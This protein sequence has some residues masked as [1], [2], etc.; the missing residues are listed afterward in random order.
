MRSHVRNRFAGA[1]A[2]VCVSALAA[3]AQTPP[4]P[5]LYPPSDAAADVAAALAASK[6]DGK[7]VLLDFGADWCPDCRVLGTLMDAPAVAPFLQANFHVVH[8]DVGRRDKNLDVVAKYHATADAWIPAVVVLDAA[9][10]AVAITDD[11]VRL[12]RRSTTSDLLALLGQWAPKKTWRP[13]ATV[14][15]HGVQ[16]DLA[17]DRDSTGRVWLSATFA[18]TEHDAHLYSKDLP[19]DGING[20]GRPT[21]L[22][23]VAPSALSATGTA[24]ANRPVELDRID[25]LNLTMPVYP[26]G[27]VT[28]RIPVDLPPAGAATRAVVSISYMACGPNGCLPPVEDKRVPIDVR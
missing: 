23:L 8:V 2:A 19:A 5:L 22:A 13:L 24:V 21:L 6:A 4:A 27:P 16:V 14:T 25:V 11:K 7:H 3:G 17:L 1:L 26:A 20:L 9:A 10:K 15:E 18:P 28:L 12:T